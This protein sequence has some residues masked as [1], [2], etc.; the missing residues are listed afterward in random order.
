MGHA[1]QSGYHLPTA[2]ALEGADMRAFIRASLVPVLLACL[3]L[4][5]G[6]QEKRPM[7]FVDSLELPTIQG[8]QLSSDGRQILFVIEK[9]DWK[10][11]R[12]VGHIYRVNADGTGQ[13][14][15]TFGERGES[16]PRWARDGHAIAFTA[17]RDSDS[18][19]Q[20]YLLD[21]SGGEARRITNHPTAPENLTWSPDG[22]TIFFT[23]SD[24]KTPEQREKDRLQDDVYSFEETNFQQKHL[25][26]TDLAGK[27][28]KITDGDFS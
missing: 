14:Q 10:S 26:T 11:N 9:S 25:W 3:S 12:R 22:R 1:R 24:P 28:K 15:L 16:S 13:L 20:I 18:N 8:P 2:T 5:L 6:A 23:A 17:R 27:T 21:A 19:N 7:T 4:S